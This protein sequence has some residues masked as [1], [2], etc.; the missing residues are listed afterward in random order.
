MSKSGPRYRGSSPFSYQIW[1]LTESTFNKSKHWSNTSSKV[2][3]AV[4]SIILEPGAASLQG[5]SFHKLPCDSI[6][7]T[8]AQL[9]DLLTISDW[10]QS[11]LYELASWQW[12]IIMQSMLSI[13]V[14]DPSLI[15]TLLPFSRP[16]PAEDLVNFNFADMSFFDL[17][18]RRSW[19]VLND[20]ITCVVFSILWWNSSM[21]AM[22]WWRMETT[23][24]DCSIH[25]TVSSMPRFKCAPNLNKLRTPKRIFMRKKRER[26]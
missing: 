6:C 21:V 26:V 10:G 18:I 1:Y 22:K 5:I 8:S 13:F 19:S 15:L 2:L 14:M 11:F 12:G 24:P 4:W 16:V 17:R 7:P 20:L 25:V 3:T 23:V 9:F